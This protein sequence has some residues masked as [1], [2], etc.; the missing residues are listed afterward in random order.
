MSDI[1]T[2]Y[3]ILTQNARQ[4]GDEP[5]AVSP[6]QSLTHNEVL[7]R[8]DRLATGLSQTGLKS[9]DRICVLAQNSIEYLELYGACA[10][11]GMI[12]TP[13]NWRLSAEEVG[14]VLSLAE[15][16]C[17]IVGAEHVAQLEGLE[18]GSIDSKFV[19]GD[20]PVEGFRPFKQLYADAS[21]PP[22]DVAGDDPFVIISTAAVAGIPRGAV[23]THGNFFHANNQV[24]DAVGL[25]PADRH[26]A[27]L[28]LFH[29]TGLGLALATTAAGGANVVTPAFDPG[30][31]AQMIDK[32]GVTLM[33]DFPPVLQMLMEARGEASWE[34]L[35]IV[36]GLDSPD[37]IQQLQSETGARFWT[38]FGQAETTG[39]VTIGPADERPG[40]AGKPL[41][42][43]TLRLVDESDQDVPLGQPGEIAVQGPLVFDGYW[44]DPDATEFAGRNG[45]HHTGD[46]GRFDEDGYLFYAGRKPEK[47]LIKSGGE[48]VYP[49]EVEHVILDLPQVAAVCV[50]GVPDEKYGEAVKAVVEL[51]PGDELGADAVQQAVANRIASF[52][53]PRVVEFVE[54]LPRT[55]SGEVDRE[56]VKANHG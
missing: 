15:P 9:G 19:I 53:K 31:S 35:R 34:S 20:A 21:Q 27:A 22:A 5:A 11:T 36:F 42:L 47:E 24:I 12:A 23:L 8:V 17:L 52:K 50:I 49:A 30:I 10:K 4:R 45:W 28:P 1:Q 33:A 54:A 7:D 44:R 26:L 18:L 46:L 56:Q 41:P 32:H 51:N 25:T 3:E 38:G 14:T 39:V 16:G 13:I 48:N 29:I 2:T 55:D 40:S 37:V 43:V 6:D